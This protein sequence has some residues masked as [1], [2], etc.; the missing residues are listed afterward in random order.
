MWT[1]SHNVCDIVRVRER[2]TETETEFSQL[3]QIQIVIIIKK[4][5]RQS[6]L[7]ASEI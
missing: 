6:C 3:Y 5:N 4:A 2:E 1:G 7:K